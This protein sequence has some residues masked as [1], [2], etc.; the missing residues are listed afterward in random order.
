M[1]RVEEQ[2]GRS[3]SRLMATHSPATPKSLTAS[4]EIGLSFRSVD[5]RRLEVSVAECLANERDR[6]LSTACEPWA[7]GAKAL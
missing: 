7:C 4:L 2:L 5:A 3:S 1:C 6:S